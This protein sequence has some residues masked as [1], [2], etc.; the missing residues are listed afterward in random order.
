[1]RAP[2]DAAEELRA[3]IEAAVERVRSA[4]LDQFLLASALLSSLDLERVAIV[5]AAAIRSLLEERHPDGLD[6][7]DVRAVLTRCAQAAAWYP[8]L[9]VAMLLLV[10]SGALGAVDPDEQPPAGRSLLTQHASVV[11]ADLTAAE[12]ALLAGHLHRSIAELRRAQT[13]EMP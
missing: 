7:D 2:S 1:M 4:D 8:D 9:D 12:P 11:L 6:A 3:A 13:I 10:L 5:Q